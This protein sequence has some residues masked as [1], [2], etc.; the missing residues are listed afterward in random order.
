M[1]SNLTALGRENEVRRSKLPTTQD[2][3]YQAAHTQH[4]E[5]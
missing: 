4:N 2:R 5:E 1:E 3:P